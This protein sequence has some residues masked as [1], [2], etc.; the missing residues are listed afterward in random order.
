ME[1]KPSILHYGNL[2]SWIT[3][4]F[5][6][7]LVSIFLLT[8]SC[9]VQQKKP[10][11]TKIEKPTYFVTVPIDKFSEIRTPCVTINIDDRAF[12]MELDLGYR[13]DL[14][15]AKEFIDSIGSKESIRQKIMYN[16]RGR[17]LITNQYRIPNIKIQNATFT[18][19]ILQ[20]EVREFLK[21]TTFVRD[22]G[23]PSPREHGKL[24]WEL[25]CNTTL[26]VDI[27]NSQLIMC[28]SPGT[29]KQHGYCLENF[30]QTPL[31]LERGLVE[32]ETITPE[33]PLRCMLDT[34]ATWNI[35]N[36]AIEE[37]KSIDQAIWEPEN[38][39]EY[40]FFKIS[41]KDFG[42]I[43]FCRIPI[44][45]PIRI[46]GVLGMDF[47]QE[48]LVFLDFIRKIAYFHPY[49]AEPLKQEL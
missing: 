36:R 48:N 43:P 23:E 37:G 26:L 30:T 13:G 11:P 38:I 5:Q 44:Q 28:D 25:F 22:G 1:G 29:L 17:E 49:S 45:A 2:L 33:G 12:S 10:S 9:T 18:K 35:L 34:G 27:K 24:G 32:I 7:F 16:F 15:L 31:L 41:E 14:K 47:F 8:C 6:R 19:I 46:D 21:D 4:R 40:P 20:E 39:L 3:M 42:K